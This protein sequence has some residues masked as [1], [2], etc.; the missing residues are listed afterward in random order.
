[1]NDEWKRFSYQEM[2]MHNKGGDVDRLVG[3]EMAVKIKSHEK[4]SMT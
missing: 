1:M 2:I 4:E 3:L